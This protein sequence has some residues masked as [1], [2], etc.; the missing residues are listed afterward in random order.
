LFFDAIGDLTFSGPTMN[1]D[2]VAVLT[3]QFTGGSNRVFDRPSLGFR[4]RSTRV[5]QDGWTLWAKADFMPK[6]I[7]QLAICVGRGKFRSATWDGAT[8][9]FGKPKV[10]IDAWVFAGV[11]V[12]IGDAHALG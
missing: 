8:H 6:P 9:G 11:S 10:G 2:L 7:C 12:P 4:S 5:E 3:A 1:Q